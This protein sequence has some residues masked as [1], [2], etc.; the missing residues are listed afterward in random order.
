MNTTES[1]QRQHIAEESDRAHFGTHCVNCMP[2]DCPIYVLVKDGKVVREEAAGVVPTVEAGVPDMNPMICQKGL[3]WSVE[4]DAED[5]IPT[6]MRRAGER[7]EGRWQRISWDEALR[8]V[9][10]AMIDAIEDV[11]PEAVVMEMSP[12]IAATQPSS[13]FMNALGGQ[14]LDV[15]A[16]INDFFSGYQQ[17]FGKFSFTASIDDNFHCD[18]ILIWHSNPAHTL[19]PAYH[20]NCEARY[21]GAEVA[22][23]STDVS[24]SHCHVDYHVPVRHGTDAALALAMAQV[25]IAED[26]VDWGFAASQTDLSLLVRTDDGRFLRQSDVEPEGRDDRFYQGHPDSG[27]VPADPAHLGLDFEPLRGGELEVEIASG[28]RIHVEP[29]CARVRRK[30]DAEFTPEQ[31]SPICEA[32]P[33]TIRMLARKIAA[34]RTRI[35]LGAG[36]CKYYHGD[37][38]TRSMLLLLALTGNWGK[39]GAGVGAWCSS[40]FDGLSSVMVKSEPGVE[41][42]RE[43][44]QG[45]DT[46]RAAIQQQDPTLTGELPDRVLLKAATGRTIY[47]AAFFW[48]LHSGFRERWNNSDWNDPGMPRDF[49][50]YFE[51]ACR[52]GAWANAVE[53]AEHKPPRVLLEV[54]GN[55]LRRT[56]GGKGVL[57]ENLWPKLD[58]IICID[59]RMSETAIHSDIV[60][61]A[62]Q[63]YE[64]TGFGMPTP[65]PFMLAMSNAVVEPLQRGAR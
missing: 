61:P 49:H 51:E 19:I 5:R 26:R 12:E 57:L 52:S 38:M 24:P 53:V 37:L 23:I 22:L 45:I 3:A 30:L 36:V 32:H 39:K 59:Y 21:R 1:R 60:L 8:E 47:P 16:T 31:A 10:D 48:Y 11:G 56:R 14:V 9:A 41:A 40:L 33:D 35:G 15:D 42:G 54:G 34:G 44:F 17:T 63:H 20:Y 65:W 43:M 13:R 55:T 58:K 46:M 4:Q 2:G 50:S 6:P 25:V 64:K 7:G 28:S 18:L 62:T 27:I 29:L